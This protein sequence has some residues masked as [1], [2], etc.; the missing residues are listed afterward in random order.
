MIVLHRVLAHREH[1]HTVYIAY[2]QKEVTA[3][4]GHDIIER[5]EQK[6]QILS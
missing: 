6:G 1:C 2:V 4:R 5:V 3:W